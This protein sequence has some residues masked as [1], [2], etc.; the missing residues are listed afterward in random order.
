M[1]AGPFER[2]GTNCQPVIEL[3]HQVGFTGYRQVVQSDLAGRRQISIEPLKQGGVAPGFLN[4][5]SQIAELLG[6]DSL[7][8]TSGCP[9]SVG[10]VSQCSE[11][12]EFHRFLLLLTPCR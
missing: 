9:E 3:T 6:L 8:S 4:E 2:K 5:T 12:A 7:A 10:E 11:K 1:F